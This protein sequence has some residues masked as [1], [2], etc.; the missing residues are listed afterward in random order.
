MD[1]PVVP[2]LSRRGLL[3]AGLA[4]AASIPL[5][6]GAAVATVSPS[7]ALEALPWARPKSSNL[8]YEAFGVC[9]HPNFDNTAYRHTEAWID[10]L[11]RVGAGYFRGLYAHDKSLTLV[12][13]RLARSHDIKWGMTVCPDLSY[14]TTELVRRIK[15]IAGNAADVCL[16]VEGIN[17][18][19]HVRDGG[20]VP[21]DWVKRTVA[22]QKVIWQTVKG[23]SRLAHV[24]VV[25]P[26]LHS[27]KSTEQQY[28]ALRDAGLVQYMDYAGIHR[29]HLGEYPDRLLDER[30]GWVERFW[31]GKPVWITETGY[32]N[33][34][35]RSTGHKPVP[36][37]VSA[38]YAP[39]TLLEAVDRNCKVSWYELLDDPDPLA[40]DD[41]ESNFGMYATA[42]DEAPPWRAKPVVPV[43]RALLAQLKDPGPAYTPPRMQLEV[44]TDADDVRTTLVGKRDGTVT[45]Y[46]RRA[47]DCW[48]PVALKPIVVTP[49]PV[50][51]KTTHATWTLAVTHAVQSIVVRTPGAS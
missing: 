5:S 6:R 50:V 30:L 28:R 15:H 34:L 13:T 46:V 37:D 29:Y 7:L 35:H 8:V 26:S 43:M 17:E 24:K 21:A 40:K 12:T 39:S 18:P 25:G 16:Y 48:D 10:G 51:V 27:G 44:T 38:V 23:D 41:T 49:V 33:A 31:G 14:P 32:T 36:E 11:V 22:I 9:S 1:D 42:V 45:L 3:L 20:K 19:N 4:G 2:S 47:T